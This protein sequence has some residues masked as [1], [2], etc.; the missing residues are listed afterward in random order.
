MPSQ[1]EAQKRAELR[2]AFLKYLPKRLD[3]LIRRGRRLCVGGWDINALT[4]FYQEVQNLAGASGRYGILDAGELLFGM[5]QLLTPSMEQVRLPDPEQS[6]TFAKLLDALQRVAERQT[7]PSRPLA[8]SA[9]A[10]LIIAPTLSVYPEAVAPPANYWQRWRDAATPADVVLIPLVALPDTAQVVAPTAATAAAA[11]ASAVVAPARRP[12]TASAQD[13]RVL[14][15]ADNSALSQQIDQRLRAL[16]YPVEVMDNVDELKEYLTAFAP[17]M[18]IVDAHFVEA[19]ESIGEALRVVRSRSINRVALAVFAESQEMSIRLRAMRAGADAFILLPQPDADVQSRILELLDA[20]TSNP[21]RVLII[22][23]DRSQAMFAESILR[24]AGMETRAVNDPMSALAELDSFDPELILMDLYMPDCD[25]IE[26]TTLIR[27]RPAY[28]NI[29]IVFL[30]GEHDEEKRFD[31]LA[32]GGDD[33]LEKPI[34]PK[35]LISAVT[36]RVRRARSTL[37]RVQAHNPRDSVS[38]LYDRGYVLERISELLAGEPLDQGGVLFLL[39]DGVQPLRERLGLIAFEQLLAQVGAFIAQQLA[40]TDLAARY[41]DTSFVVLLHAQSEAA[42]VE[43]A[44][45]LRGSFG[46]HLFESGE[47]SISIAACIGIAGFGQNL[48]DTGSLLNAAERAAALSRSSPDKRA[49]LFQMAVTST[50]DGDDAELAELIRA[51][52]KHDQ[53]QL[54]YQPIASLRGGG[55]AQFEVLLRLRGDGGKL[56][57]GSAL[58]PIAERAG[59][60]QGIDRWVLSRALMVIAERNR[61]G[62]PLR[63]FVSQS[64]ESVNDVQRASWLKQII[65]TRKANAE[66]LVIQLRTPD[67]VARVRQ[68]AFFAEQMNSLGVKI[69]LTQFEPTMA[70]FQLLQH[71]AAEFV[72]V[73]PRFTSVDGQTPK[74]RAELRQTITKVRELGIRIVAPRV[75]DAQCAAALWTTGV[76]YIQGNFV[77]PASQDLEFDFAA[78]AL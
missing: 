74:V 8:V 78:A 62:H 27:E 43:F 12:P 52:L 33:Y 11:P 39:L 28:I 16:Q 68:T 32:V 23:D 1:D 77:Q 51:A 40:A 21:Y 69:C 29:P 42:M 15:L 13:K 75:E 59:L 53:F 7:G 67:A 44:E 56:Y 58:M 10:G 20:D 50:V 71:V 2:Q 30:S 26:L 37:R 18:V 46:E 54:L 31:A 72:K 14:H 49:A 9:T 38:G 4:L 63:L 5:E 24:K 55:E 65:E 48:G 64:I 76:D 3:T 41:G 70:N 61:D 25:G 66:N 6:V 60:T 19:L 36:N 73:S 45:A 47:Q 57:T 17:A 35:H 34:R 22:E